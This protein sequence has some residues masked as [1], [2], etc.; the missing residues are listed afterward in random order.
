MNRYNPSFKRS[1]ASGTR[2][3]K[4]ALK[5][6]KHKSFF[7]LRIS[8]HLCICPHSWT[9]EARQ[10]IYR[11]IKRFI[12]RD[13]KILQRKLITAPGIEINFSLVPIFPCTINRNSCAFFL[14]FFLL[15][16]TGPELTSVPIF[17]YFICG[18]PTAA[19]LAKRCHVPTW[20][21]NRR[22]W[23]HRSE[24]CEFNCCATR[25]APMCFISKISFIFIRLWL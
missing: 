21:A 20:D 12:P 10:L 23:G 17:F 15:R 7:S 8:L 6:R 24:M 14:C 5:S 2:Q 16:K 18:M 22:T 19:W 11:L 1:F 13:K 3:K 25:P 9:I 4:S